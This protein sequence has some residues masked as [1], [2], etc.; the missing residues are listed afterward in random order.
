MTEQMK[1]T[2]GTME[3]ISGIIGDHQFATCDS[4]CID[5]GKKFTFEFERTSETGL[6]MKNGVIARKKSNREFMCK[7]DECFQKNDKFG[8]D[9]EV[10]SRVVGYLRPV[11]AWNDAKQSEFKMRKPTSAKDIE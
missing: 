5:C 3:E 11:S 7:C 10:Y 8:G 6:N 2:L 9:T 1:D 4:T